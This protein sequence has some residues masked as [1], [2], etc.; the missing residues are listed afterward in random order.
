MLKRYQVLEYQIVDWHA[1][2]FQVR[3]GYGAIGVVER[4]DVLLDVGWPFDPPDH[5]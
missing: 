5:R 1:R 3:V 2:H 4:H